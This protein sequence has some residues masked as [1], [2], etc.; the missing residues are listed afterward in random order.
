MRAAAAPN[1]GRIRALRLHNSGLVRLSLRDPAEVVMRLGAVQ[2]QDFA[3]AKWGLGLRMKRATDE[4]VED[5]FNRGEILRTHVM[6]PTWHFVPREDIRWMIELTAPR[7]KR[8]MAP[9]NRQLE[10]TEGVVGRA[11]EI[12]VRALAGGNHLTRQEL[13]A[14]LEAGG[15]AARGPRLNHIVMG[16]ELDGIICSGA[17]RGKQLTYA[18]L[19]ERAPA[20][21]PVD[22][23]EALSKLATRYFSSH[24]PAQLKDFA[25]W[26]G[27]ATKDAQEALGLIQACLEQMS[28]NGKTYWFAPPPKAGR[29]GRPLALLLSIY[30]EYTIAY[31]DRGDM[32]EKRDIERIVALGNALTSVMVLDGTVAG[33]WKRLPRKTTVAIALSPFRRL[34]RNEKEA[35][36]REVARFGKFFGVET[37]LA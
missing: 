27:L 28:F 7:V 11:A 18:L 22:R 16:V 15:I 34:N 24:G 20:A 4:T 5:A 25:W 8:V 37:T 32:S 29:S 3:A 9:Y 17:K 12:I 2:A 6:R 1:S 14:R 33:T 36:E 13:A 30:D 26:S 31:R 23:G 35:F 10:V 19:D 21:K